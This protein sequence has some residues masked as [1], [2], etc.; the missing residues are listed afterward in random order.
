MDKSIGAHLLIFDF[1]IFSPIGSDVQ[2]HA[3]SPLQ[4]CQFKNTAH[5]SVIGYHHRNKFLPFLV[6]LLQ[7]VLL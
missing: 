1:F 7:V 6:F 4:T 3:S 2:N 5:L